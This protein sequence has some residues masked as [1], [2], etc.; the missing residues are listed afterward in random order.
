MS[1]VINKYVE[2]DLAQIGWILNDHDRV[3]W[4][5]TFYGES[6]GP[7]ETL[8]FFEAIK[9]D[10]SDDQWEVREDGTYLGC[11]T[12]LELAQEF[13]GRNAHAKSFWGTRRERRHFTWRFIVRD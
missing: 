5:A 1:T 10:D 7:W 8:T 9:I 11:I 6:E 4:E 3:L 13:L 2:D 12:A